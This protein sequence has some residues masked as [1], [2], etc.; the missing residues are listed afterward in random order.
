MR[1]YAFVSFVS[2]VSPYT[3]FSSAT[4]TYSPWPGS[5]TTTSKDTKNYFGENLSGLYYQKSNPITND[6]IPTIYAIKN[7]PSFLYKLQFNGKE[8]WKAVTVDGWD[9]DDF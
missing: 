1:F 5:S 2:F 6:N 9:D 3:Q 7:N 8:K 4:T